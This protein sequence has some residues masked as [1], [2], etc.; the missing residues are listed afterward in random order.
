MIW[1]QEGPSSYQNQNLRNGYTSSSLL[2][3]RNLIPRRVS[4]AGCS[5]LDHF[6]G[7]SLAGKLLQPPRFVER[8]LHEPQRRIPLA[9]SS[10]S[11]PARGDA[12]M[13]RG[14][15]PPHLTGWRP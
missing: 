5:R 15:S 8:A 6:R 12:T 14:S 1:L 10:A 3:Q 4:T 7:F 9:D 11:R 2:H 13:V